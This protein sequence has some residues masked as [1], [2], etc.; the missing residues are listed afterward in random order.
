MPTKKKPRG[1]AFSNGHDPRR[2]QHPVA[3]KPATL[4]DPTAGTEASFYSDMRHVRSR[5]AS[6]DV[7]QGQ[8]DCRKW[9]RQNLSTFMAKFTE[10]EKAHLAAGR[11]RSQESKTRDG[12]GQCPTCGQ[13]PESLDEGTEAASTVIE[14]LLEVDVKAVLAERDIQA[15]TRAD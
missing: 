13:E 7:T 10:V 4:P 8:R 6:E 14:R 3:A 5:P 11:D 2:Y 1:K 15:K 9:K 12:K